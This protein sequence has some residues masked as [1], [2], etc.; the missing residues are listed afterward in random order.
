LE[1]MRMEDEKKAPAATASERPAVYVELKCCCGAQLFI[2]SKS[3]QTFDTYLQRIATEF[4]SSHKHT[5]AGPA[6][7]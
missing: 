7:P 2:E 3:A 5:C 1:E 4:I 6:K